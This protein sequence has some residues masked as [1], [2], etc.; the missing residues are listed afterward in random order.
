MQVGGERK[1]T[2][3]AHMAYGKKGQ[4]GIP[5]NST[6]IFGTFFDYK[7]YADEYLRLTLCRSEAS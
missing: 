4:S 7:L 5:P 2:I 6:L 1:L 3:P